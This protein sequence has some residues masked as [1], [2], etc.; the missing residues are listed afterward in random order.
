MNAFYDKLLE[1]LRRDPR[2]FSASGEFLRGAAYEA[3]MRMDPALLR[4][5]LDEP[6]LKARFFT[7]VEGVAVF[8]KV[9]FGWIIANRSLLPD[10]YTR[11]RGRIGLADSRGD[12]ITATDDVELVFPFKDCVLEGGQDKKE[13]K[14]DEVFYNETLAPDQR[15]RLLEPKALGGA[16]RYSVQGEGPAD[17]FTE[18]DNLLIKGN[19]LLALASLLPRYRGKV[20]CIYIDP[21]YY[22]AAKKE[23]DTF[24]YNVNFKLST[25]LVFMRNR[26]ELARELLRD[27]GAIFVQISDDGVAE[28]HRLLKEIFNRQGENNFIN[29]ITVKTKSP[30]GFAT[31]N[32]GV[33]ETA[34]Y[35]LAF[36]KHKQQW[37]YHPQYVKAE[38]DTNYKWV[39]PNIGA[40]CSQWEIQDLQEYLSVQKGYAS[41]KE[42]LKELGPVVLREL[43]A[44]Y[45]LEH[46]DQ[47]FRY[48]AIGSNAG[49]EVL[50]ARERSEQEPEAVWEVRRDKLYD[51]Y[52]RG[53]QEMTFYAK[54]V[55]EIDG[56]RVPSMQLTNIWTDTPYEG[57]AKE[58]QVTLKGGKKPER[59][60]RR[61][62]EMATDPGDLVLD[63]HMGSGTTCAVAHKLGRR[64]IG[65]EQLDYGENDSL[66]RLRG[67]V[68]GDKTG[69]S[70][71]VGWKGGGSF[72]SCELIRLNQA[73]ADRIG[74]ARRR[75]E[76]AGLWEEIRATGFI[77][78]RVRPEEIDPQAEDFAALS[79]KEQ[80]C[81]LLELLDKNMLYV[82]RCDMDDAEF[83]VSEEDKRFTRCFYGEESGDAV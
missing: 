52:I 3:A 53:G 82:N 83:A 40:P 69:I 79:L 35:I 41:K 45:A 9:G 20:K 43:A 46:P 22:F 12:F 61:I 42:A 7:E 18:T 71:A 49:R 13:Q 33:F 60:L 81:L 28:L 58:G 72:V 54:K 47:V 14:R 24:A 51:V 74:S 48:T 73:F 39:I 30:S 76:L 15:D 16:R 50:E 66:C 59:L 62:I 23:E 32:A 38:Y 17:T 80:K 57:I 68:E 63:Y 6:E 26:L 34:E 70:K 10:S 21:P 64:Y 55:R 78:C 4:L 29:K 1:I 25:W 11:Y 27:D 19:N 8:D 2:F 5:L 37:T 75:D 65:V 44:A 56:E 31:V 36:A 77:S 67:V